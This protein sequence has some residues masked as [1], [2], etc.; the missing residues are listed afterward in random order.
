MAIDSEMQDLQAVSQHVL[1][2]ADKIKKLELE[3]RTVPP[4]STRFIELSAEIERLAADL[5][6]VSASETDL[7]LE[8]AGASNLPTI[9]EADRTSG[10]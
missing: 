3:K 6:V 7:A 5:G 4:G 9:E 1:T 2:A 8:V 10:N